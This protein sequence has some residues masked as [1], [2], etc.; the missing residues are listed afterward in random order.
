MA[1]AMK[2]TGSR[3]RTLSWPSCSFLSF[4]CLSASLR[5][6]SSCSFEQVAPRRY[7]CWMQQVCGGHCDAL[8]SCRTICS[9]FGGRPV[10]LQNRG[11]LSGL[12]AASL[13][14]APLVL[15]HNVVLYIIACKYTVDSNRRGLFFF[16][17]FFFFF[18]CLDNP[19][20]ARL[21][22]PCPSRPDQS[23]SA[24]TGLCARLPCSARHSILGAAMSPG[25]SP[26]PLP[27][28]PPPVPQRPGAVA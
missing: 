14:R 8:A 4:S 28:D 5:F 7:V 26:T 13:R 25:S 18:L 6:S 2:R 22:A 15:F 1:M 9:T 27:G 21:R 23:R 3:P 12:Q 19:L 20:T 16:F 10:D 24:G 11:R 17:F